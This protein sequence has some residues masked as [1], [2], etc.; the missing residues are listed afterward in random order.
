MASILIVDDE[1]MIR[2]ELS[3]ALE[4]EEFD[5]TTAASAA[6]ALEICVETAFDVIVTDLKM[7]KMG[8]LEFLR[9]LREKKTEALLFVVS[10]H[11]AKSNE[12]E[13]LDLGAI[14]CLSKPLD[15]DLLIESINKNQEN[16]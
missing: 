6:E 12:D 7:P 8:G 13:A 11:G 14:A 1:E 5:V 3:E 16:A 4:F 15:V 9:A 10:G 2:E